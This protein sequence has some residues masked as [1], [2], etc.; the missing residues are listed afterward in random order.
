MGEDDTGAFSTWDYVV[1]VA[2]LLISAGIGVYYRFT[3]GRQKTTQ[4][5]LL[6]DRN[7]SV[8]PVSI[9]LMASF[10]SAITLLGVT[11]EN[12]AYGTQFVVINF[13]YGL[14][15]P[16][17]AYCFLPVF[18]KLQATSAYHYLELRFGRVARLAASIAFSLQMVLYMGIVVYAPALA[19]EAVTGL[20]KTLSV[21]SIGLVCTFYSTIG[22]MK[23]VVVTDVFQSLLMFVAVYVVIIKATIDAGG[24]AEVWEIAVNGSRVE[25]D[26]FDP[27]PTVRHTWWSL[28]IGG[29][30]T[31]L[32]LYAVNQAQV[33][34][35]LTLKDL[36]KSQ[37]ALWI[38][39]PVLTL[40]SLSTSFS[41]LAIYSKYSGCDPLKAGRI[42]AYDQLMPLYVVDSLRHLPGL[43][44]L[45]VAGIFSGS[46][47]T[48]SSAVNSL[49]A[50]TLED[51]FKPAYASLKGTPLPEVW[52]GF[53][54]KIL[55]LLYGLLCLGMAYAAE[56]LGGVL[57]A[58]LTI[59]GV[60]GGPLFGLFTLGMFF[61]SV[62]QIGA[63]TGLLIGIALSLWIG[64]GGPKPPP[65]MLPMST[66]SCSPR[67]QT[68]LLNMSASSRVQMTRL[69]QNATTEV[70]RAA[71]SS[72]DYFLLYKLSYM[73]YVV[74]GFLVTLLVGIIVSYVISWCRKEPDTVHN[75]DLFAPLVRGYVKRRYQTKAPV[76]DEDEVAMKEKNG[77]KIIR[78]DDDADRVPEYNENQKLSAATPL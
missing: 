62:N 23:A 27:D 69:I 45:F 67:I 21:L 47:S 55:A 7:L 61:P 13:S 1:L 73:W 33:Q 46:L 9:S 40:L 20:S 26:N 24:L 36:K 63:V 35:L 10:M 16:I 64:F 72:D 54:S 57:Q 4:E 77:I 52:S 29:G 18:F 42:S 74:I 6:G 41:G 56:Y 39:W 37:R 43:P 30:L 3:G 49:A 12:Y 31:Y 8:F 34:R 17:A 22:G 25:F 65:K 70:T 19:L 38:S 75:P 28:I 5:Y 51:Y 53:I 50:V 59:F 66:E 58:S 15:T 76:D 14:A 2:M 11:M 32:S 60:V 68:D 44:G 48:V 71:D 78:I